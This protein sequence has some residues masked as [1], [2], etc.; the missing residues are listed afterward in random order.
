MCPPLLASD[1]QVVEL[2]LQLDGFGL[3][4]LSA[5]LGF[6]C[7]R[8]DGAFYLWVQTPEPD[9][10]AFVAH[11]KQ[12]NL[13]LVPGSSFAGPGY[14]RLAYCVSPDMIRRSLPAFAKLAADYNLKK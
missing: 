13:L 9:D 8:P 6:S 1:Q 14:V 2:S 5:A 3:G 11:A 7:V 10:K 12:Y 4:G